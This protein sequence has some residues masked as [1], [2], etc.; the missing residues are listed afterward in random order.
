MAI[1]KYMMACNVNPLQVRER[2]PKLFM[3]PFTSDRKRMSTLIQDGS[4]QQFLL[5]GA[6][7]LIVQSCSKLLDLQSGHVIPIDA[8]LRQEIDLAILTFAKRSLRTIGLAYKTVQSVDTKNKD[9]K[10][11][12]LAEKSDFVLVGIAGIKD[13]IRPEVPD[14]VQQCYGAGITVKM[15]TGDNKVTARAIAKDCNIIHPDEPDDDSNG[16]VMEGP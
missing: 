4:S 3:E 9:E 16:R 8:G 14:A 10:G 6:S 13:V 5:K 1:L 2:H 7:E 11:V 12:L 15:V